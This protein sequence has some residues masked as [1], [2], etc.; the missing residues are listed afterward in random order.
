MNERYEPDDLKEALRVLKAGGIILYPTDTV[1]GIGC[2]ATNEEAVQRIYSLKRRSDS[3]AML[4]LVDAPGRLQA[5]VPEI[6]ATAQTLLEHTEGEDARPLTIIY[7]DARNL[8]PS[9][10][11]EDG[12]IGIRITEEHFTKALCA[13]LKKPVV[14]TSA[15]LS[16]EPAAGIFTDIC[17]EI[18]DGVDYIC[19]YRRNDRTCRKPSAVIK[20]NADNTFTIIRK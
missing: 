13:G 3:K 12:S 17:S 7:P 5:Y 6:P 18:R 19:R 4:V 10:L 16:G 8:A 14:S 2:D 1:W 11:A 9:L 15:N 20:V